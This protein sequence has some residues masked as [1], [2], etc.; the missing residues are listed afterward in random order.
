M[1]KSVT[2]KASHQR[3]LFSNK[4][5]NHYN[6][7]V[8]YNFTDGINVI[9]GRNGS[10]KSV[11]LKLIKFNCC[12]SNDTSYPRFIDPLHIN[13]NIFNDEYYTIP[14]YIEER[15]F[16][17]RGLPKSSINWDGSIVHYLTPEWFNPKDIL[18]RIDTPFPKGKELFSTGESIAKIMGSHSK[19]ESVLH[20]LMSLFNLNIKYDPPLTHVN[21][22]WIK[23]DSVFQ[24][25][26]SKFP[27]D[28][29]P[30]L[31][32][33]ELDTNLDLD[34]QKYFWDY[35][36]YL[37]KKWQIIVV[38]HSYFAFKRTDVNHIPLNKKYFNTIKKL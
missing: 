26:I 29:K 7:D 2:I 33:D 9:T 5:Y 15:F 35:L 37:N 32:I 23:A 12:I 36:H 17:N 4:L 38:S 31:L 11:L 16:E 20:L 27:Q 8:I 19:G 28:G 24:E 6:K 18:R 1:I 3:G 14:E 13:K 34:N 22:S 21:D 10:G 30:T 25:W